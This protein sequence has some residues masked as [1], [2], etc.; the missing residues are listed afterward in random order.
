MKIKATGKA[1]LE[2]LVMMKDASNYESVVAA[3]HAAKAE[4][5]EMLGTE[6]TQKLKTMVKGTL[7][8]TIHETNLLLR[9]PRTA[10]MTY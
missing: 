6:L 5:F 1:K 7:K 3:L 10:S 4:T 2:D 8:K 9:N